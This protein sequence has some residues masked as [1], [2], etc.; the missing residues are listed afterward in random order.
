MGEYFRPATHPK[1][2]KQHRCDACHGPIAV[3]EQ[4]SRQT[5]FFAGRAFCN[6]L[7]F[8]CAD[9]LDDDARELGGAVEFTPGSYDVP[10][11]IAGAQA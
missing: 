1:A 4:Y 2:R 9:A 6:K 5:G 8:E 10:E 7:H 3:G 11:R